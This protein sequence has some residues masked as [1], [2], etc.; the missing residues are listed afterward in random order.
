MVHVNSSTQKLR[1]GE[2]N[3]AR[4]ECENGHLVKTRWE[5]NGQIA[6]FPKTCPTC[7]GKVL[8]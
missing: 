5:R 1:S 3:H 7:G 4:T 2:S 6:S 8:T